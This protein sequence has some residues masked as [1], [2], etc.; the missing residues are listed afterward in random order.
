MVHR[1]EFGTLWRINDGGDEPLMYVEVKNATLK[2][3]ER[4]KF[5]L[6]VPPTMRTA[7][8][9]VAWTFRQTPQTYMPAMET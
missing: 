7:H 2:D 4:R 3:G 9:A 8:E 5:F 6:R 1:D